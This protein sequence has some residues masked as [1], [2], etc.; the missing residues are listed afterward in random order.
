MG[1]ARDTLVTGNG[2]RNDGG[3]ARR[4]FSVLRDS[5]NYMFPGPQVR[6]LGNEVIELMAK[7]WQREHGAISVSGDGKGKGFRAHLAEKKSD[8]EKVVRWNF[9]SIFDVSASILLHLNNTD[10]E[11]PENTETIP[12]PLAQFTSG[13]WGRCRNERVHKFSHASLVRFEWVVNVNDIVVVVVHTGHSGA[14]ARKAAENDSM[15]RQQRVS[16]SSSFAGPPQH[17]SAG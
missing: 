9:G 14:R 12:I 2:N 15:T 6:S 3:M 1:G 4:A 7:E 10:C 16:S 5:N 13:L 17:S 8:T 11:N